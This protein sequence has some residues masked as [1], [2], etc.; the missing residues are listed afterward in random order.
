MKLIGYAV[1]ALCLLAWPLSVESR[2]IHHVGVLVA[3]SVSLSLSLNMTLRIGQLSA[4]QAAFMGLGA[5]AS[6]LLMMRLS[7][8]F[9]IAFLCAGVIVGAF[10]IV[11]G[12]IFLRVKGVYFV[13]LTFALGQAVV[14]LFQEWVSLFG[15]NN[16]LMG[17]PQASLFGFVFNGPR[18]FYYLALALA[19]ATFLATTALF[20][21]RPGAILHSLAEDDVLSQSLGLD[22]LSYRV[23]VFAISAVFAGW[24]GSLYAHYTGFLSPEAFNFWTFVDALVVNVVGGL[25][26]PV[27]PVIGAI[28]LVPLPELLRDAKQYQMLSYGLLLLV[29]V[30]MMPTGLTGAFRQ[31]LWKLKR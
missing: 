18:K 20:R 24:T 5:Y 15:G 1:F 22:V 25:F 12:P 7:A 21:G 2:Y 14:L 30:F 6:A 19:G 4:A 28:L 31:L 10:A 27:G 8:P 29:F 9:W 11:L 3:I 13:L 16:G 26:W 23:A 17:V